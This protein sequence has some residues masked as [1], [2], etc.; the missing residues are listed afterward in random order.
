M[1]SF[2]Q[3]RSDEL[4]LHLAGQL[5]ELFDARQV[6]VELYS[7]IA[8]LERHILVLSRFQEV[9]AFLDGRVK[10]AKLR[11]K[12]NAFCPEQRPNDDAVVEYLCSIVETIRDDQQRAYNNHHTSQGS[13]QARLVVLERL[14]RYQTEEQAEEQRS[15]HQD[16]HDPGLMEHSFHRYKATEPNGVGNG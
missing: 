9:D 11:A 6:G 3:A 2:K 1:V 8:V 16:P 10:D 13:F 4:L 12:G 5:G 15:D 14:N 7:P